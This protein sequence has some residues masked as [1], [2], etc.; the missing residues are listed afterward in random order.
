MI[1]A[2]TQYILALV[3]AV[4]ALSGMAVCIGI[5]IGKIKKHN[6]STQQK[7]DI[8]LKENAELK[9]ENVTYKKALTKITAKLDHVHFVDNE[10]R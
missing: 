8:V 4:S 10:D 3:P 1:D 2:I 7:L 6:S 9:K 5:C